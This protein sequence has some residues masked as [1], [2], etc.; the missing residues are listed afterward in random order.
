MR[1]AACVRHSRQ[2]SRARGGAARRRRRRRRPHRRRRGRIARADAAAIARPSARP[3]SAGTV[4]PGQWRSRGDRADRRGARTVSRVRALERRPA[5]SR[6]YGDDRGVAV[7]IAHRDRRHRGRGV[8]PRD[9]AQR[10]G[11]LHAQ[12]SG[13][14]AAADLRRPRR[15][16]RRLRPHPHAIRSHDR[17]G[18]R[19]QRRQRRHA[20]RRSRRLL[21]VTRTGCRTAADAVR[22]RGRGRS[23]PLDGLSKAEE[24]AARNVLQPPSEQEI[25]AAFSHTELR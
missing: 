15:G 19:G 6:G 10:H 16:A 21:A 4:H 7:D 5:A 14:A 12:H 13:R 22:L 24:F 9:A 18:A 20:V 11:D 2:P 25:L 1:V 8:L 23:D 17:L 3:R